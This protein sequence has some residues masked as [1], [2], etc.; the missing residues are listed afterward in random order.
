MLDFARLN[1]ALHR[2]GDVLDRHIGVDAVLVE[3][4]DPVHLE[5]RQHRIGGPLYMLGSAAEAGASHPGFGIDVPAELRRNYDLATHRP[6]RLADQFFVG[7]RAIRLGGV[8]EGYAQLMRA[9]DDADC[10]GMIGRLA[11]GRSKAHCPKADFGHGERAKLAAF[12]DALL[13]IARVCLVPTYNERAGSSPKGNPASTRRS[14][15]C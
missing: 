13:W 11:I 5:A 12:H 10:L 8:E 3:D 7:P 1:Q 4:V 2:A 15:R 6:E 9:A 14:A